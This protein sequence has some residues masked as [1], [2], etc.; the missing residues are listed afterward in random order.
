MSDSLVTKLMFVQIFFLALFE[1]K[2]N[3]LVEKLHISRIS[4][5][6]SG[7]RPYRIS[8]SAI[9]YVNILPEVVE[10][11]IKLPLIIVIWIRDKNTSYKKVYWVPVPVQ[12]VGTR[13]LHIRHPTWDSGTCDPVP[14][15]LLVY[16]GDNPRRAQ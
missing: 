6:M 8:S 10:L 12:H 15:Y 2:L 3:K 14:S 5:R 7:I 4:G 13:I 16:L 11:V 9:R 1:E